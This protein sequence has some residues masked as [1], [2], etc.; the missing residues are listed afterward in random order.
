MFLGRRRTGGRGQRETE[1]RLESVHVSC[2]L[3]ILLRIAPVAVI[4]VVAG[5]VHLREGKQGDGVS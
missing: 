4:V 1:R 3:R 5:D 2:V